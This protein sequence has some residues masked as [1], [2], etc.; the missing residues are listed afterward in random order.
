M[1]VYVKDWTEKRPEVGQV[2]RKVLAD[3]L[4]IQVFKA[5]EKD[6]NDE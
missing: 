2:V 6:A 1:A 3:P 5:S 4:W